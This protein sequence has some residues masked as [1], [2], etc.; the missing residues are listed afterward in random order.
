VCSVPDI[1]PASYNPNACSLDNMMPPLEA[2]KRAVWLMAVA[3]RTVP[4]ERRKR[5]SERERESELSKR[6]MILSG[7]EG[8]GRRTQTN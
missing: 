4:V 1:F 6:W 8:G 2:G 5:E 3:S 7:G